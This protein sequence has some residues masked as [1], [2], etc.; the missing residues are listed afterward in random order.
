MPIVSQ[1]G[2]VDPACLATNAPFPE[3][4]ALIVQPDHYL[5]RLMYAN[6]VSLESL[7]VPR[8]DG[9][10][11]ESEPRAVWRLF[12]A[13][14]HRF[15][16]TP[17]GAWLDFEFAEVFGIGVELGPATADRVYDE[18]L[19]RLATAEFRP[20]ALFERFRIEV[21][22]TTDGAADSLAHHEA[23]RASGWAGKVI[24][25][26]RPD[27]VFRL[28]SP[29][30]RRELAALERAHGSAIAHVGELVAALE[31][32][33]VRFRSLGATAT[34]HG[35]Q[36]PR[37]GRLSAD[38]AEAAFQRALRGEAT[39]ADQSD[40]EAHLLMEMAR[41]SIDDGLVMQLHSGV[42]RDH[43]RQLL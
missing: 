21:L 4:T 12:A 18:I 32:R 3:P 40:F 43:N 35:V 17:S 28:A 38:N 13:H 8:L 2:H 20:R 23:I 10:P 42:L 14:Y 37:T 7:G 26:F 22:A 19:E 31:Q 9:A 29:Q 41:M 16:G 25:T 36:E 24:P 39:A 1:H 27:G 11:V 34:D 6:G 5:L 33:R 30:W 15:R